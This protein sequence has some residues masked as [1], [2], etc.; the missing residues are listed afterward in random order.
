MYQSLPSENLKCMREGL[1]DLVSCVDSI[2]SK[3]EYSASDKGVVQSTMI[4]KYEPGREGGK[5]EKKE[6]GD[7]HTELDCGGGLNLAEQNG[8]AVE[9]EETIYT[10][11]GNSRHV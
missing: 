5:G 3:N 4:M 9:M 6:E 2:L 11:A 8:R 7:T 10:G 1:L